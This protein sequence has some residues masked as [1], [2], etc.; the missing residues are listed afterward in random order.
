MKTPVLCFSLSDAAK[1]KSIEF[2]APRALDAGFDLPSLN[3]VA[4]QPGAFALLETGVH[5]AIPEGWV[6]LIRDRSSI[7]L[8]GGACTAGVIDASYRGEVKV[9]FHN[10]GKVPIE[11]VTGDRIAQCVIIPHLPGA[12]AEQVDSVEALGNTNRGAG[13]FGSTGK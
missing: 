12:N 1:A 4:I 5:L 9:A 13:G 11:F 10:F 8:K 2:R 6:G 7:A 3:D